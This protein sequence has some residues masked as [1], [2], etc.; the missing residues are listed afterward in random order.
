MKRFLV[1]VTAAYAAS[2]LW[3]SSASAGLPDAPPVP[4][5][6]G[7][8]SIVQVLVAL[9]SGVLDFILVVAV[10]FVIVAGIRLIISG[11][12]EGEKDKAKKTIVYV[13]VGIIVILLARVIVTFVNNL[14]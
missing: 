5:L 1:R 6:S 14:V 8:V 10:I 7:S 3:V 2:T 4:G 12:D 9:I 13:I 11:G